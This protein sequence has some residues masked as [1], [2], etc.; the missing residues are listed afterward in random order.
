M[1]PVLPVRFGSTLVDTARLPTQPP[2][3]EGRGGTFGK[4]VGK[5]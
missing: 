5:S 2:K 3:M 4:N 1:I